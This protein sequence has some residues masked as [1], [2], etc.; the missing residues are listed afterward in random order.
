MKDREKTKK[1][2]L[3]ELV[4]LRHQI[5]EFEVSEAQRE[6]AEDLLRITESKQVDEALQESEERYRKQFEEAIDA[7]FMADLETGMLVDC[8]VAASKLVEREKSEIIGKHQSFLHPAENIKDG[9]SESFKSHIAGESSELLED[10]VITKSGQIKDVAIRA[11]KIT[12]EGRKIMQGIFRDITKLKQAEKM[13]EKK[14]EEQTLLL[15]NIQTLIWYLK[16]V[17]THGIV[18]K[19]CADFF[20]KKKEDLENKKLHDIMSSREEAE[21]CIAGNK[22][23]FEKKVTIH[24]EEWAKNA[25]GERRL[26]AITKTPKIGKNGNVEYVVCSAEDITE[27]RQTDEALRDSEVRCRLLFNGIADAVYVHEVSVEK[28]GKFYAVNDSACRMLGYTRDEFMQMEVKDID[29]AEQSEKIPS[30]HE[31]LFRDGY[32][33]FEGCHVAKD[34]RRIPVEINI[35]LFE[36]Q[37]KLMVMAVARDITEREQAQE[38]LRKSEEKFRTVADWT[39]DWEYWIS[40]EAALLYVSPSVERITGYPAEEFQRDPDTYNRIVYSEDQ[41]LWNEH[42]IIHFDK[43]ANEVSELDFRI[44]TRDGLIKWIHHICRPVFSEDGRFLGR[45]VSNRDITKR[46]Q[47]EA[48]MKMRYDLMEYAGTHSLE[49]LLQKT[50][51]EIGALTNSPV[52][53]YHF[54]E[55]DQKT[56]SLQAWSTRT[57]KEF[58]TAK[59]KGMHY[60]IDQAGVWV[61]CVHERRPLIHND[62][63]SLPHRKGL[64]EG[65][66]AVIRELVVPIMRENHVVA[67]LGIGNKPTDYTEKDA[68][69][70][71]FIADVAWEITKRKQAE[72]MLEKK[73]EEQTLLLDNIQTLIWYLKDVETQGIVNKACADFFG[74]KKEDLEN[75]KLHDI[76][77]S[78]EE[79]EICI[80]G[81]KEVFEKKVTIHTEEWAKNAKGERR[82]IAITKTP[83]IGKNGNVEYVV[84][85]AEDITESRQT[86]EALLRAEQLKV[87]GDLAV[88]LTHELK[89]SLTGIKISIEVLLDELVLSEDDRKVLMNMINETR[90]IELLMKDLLNFA[91]PSKPQLA[92]VNINDVLDTALKLSLK[93]VSTLKNHGRSID[94]VKEF[95]YH[96]PRTMADQM[97]LQQVFMNLLLNAG[98]AMQNGGSLKVQTSYDAS[99]NLIH[100]SIS[101]TGKGIDHRLIDKI[102]DPFFTT[103]PKGTGLGLSISKRL[104][105]QHRGN[106]RVETSLGKGATFN[107]VLPVKQFEGFMI[108]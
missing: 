15:D 10:R 27:S 66:A 102:F 56:L 46:K 7:I 79:A 47:A 105:E 71:S 20:G 6:K 61:D 95:D 42:E 96:I 9:F 2:L 106:I 59:G 83:K 84:C 86:D 29:I 76:M 34:G 101:D 38:A 67:I 23:V 77:S 63:I 103:K 13:L 51:D 4:E 52:G 28:P 18:N 19:A 16:D 69:L 94:V 35:Q 100:I 50:L 37:G 36:L 87:A 26:I 88:G 39:Y 53:F 81:N 55:P 21:I 25:K 44:L 74:K 43:A 104:I 3:N 48:M 49:E 91:R 108:T 62:Y 11:S 58:C 57:E 5:A 98:E 75:K 41:S 31:K 78:K 107:I 90:R 65:H 64:P 24:T 97:K 68:E 17:E 45:R 93:R 12:I 82:L 85:S 99:N 73:S 72:K 54:V 30:V 89:N 40:P 22:E 80:A 60:R 32:A 70:V 92:F 1:Q 14:S 33:L 8:N